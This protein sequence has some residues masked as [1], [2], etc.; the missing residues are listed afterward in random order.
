MYDVGN[1]D[2]WSQQRG[3]AQDLILMVLSI[4]VV[5]S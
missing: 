2:V 3:H 5:K 1:L 4:V